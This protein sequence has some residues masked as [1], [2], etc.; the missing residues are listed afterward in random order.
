MKALVL[1]GGF[2]QISLIQK[3]KKMGYFVELADWNENPPARKYA[4]KYYQVS[5][6]DEKAIEDIAIEDNISLL[7]TVCTDQALKTV[8]SVSDKLN[9]P[10]Y[11]DKETAL[12]VTNKKY[13]K[14]V[15]EQKNIP[16]AKF[17]IVENENDIDNEFE[18]PVIVKPV[19]CNSS[20][21][22][23]K[24]N[25]TTELRCA[26]KNAL[27]LSRSHNAIVEEYMHGCEYTIDAIVSNGKVSVLCIS[28]TQKIKSDS[29]FVICRTF[30]PPKGITENIKDQIDIIAQK[31][32]DNFRLN[33][34]PLLIQAINHNGIVRVIEFSARTGGG[35]KY[36]S[37]LWYTG[38]D[39]IQKTI[40]M[41][42]GINTSPVQVS[43]NDKCMLNEFIY[44]NDC[45]VSEYSGFDDALEN[46]LITQYELYRN[47]GEGVRSP[48]SS[49]DRAANITFVD[50]NFEKLY[51]K[52]N[53]VM[54]NIKVINLEG[55]DMIYRDSVWIE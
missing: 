48:R 21:G 11:I 17:R 2:P 9:L 19:D 3:L 26:V 39:I 47:Q 1:A 16:T 24:V 15:L 41:T 30:L 37:I 13:M 40:E 22:V 53:I 5:T 43:A 45:V 54:K 25:N 4:D 8:A 51:E 14:Q 27:T 7:I 18:F 34:S 44:C 38:V 33:N 52:Y 28:E 6:L 31:I 10:C 23:V 46:G 42:L 55:K 20:K 32:A 36:K 12:N 35:E 29:G 50:D 49:G